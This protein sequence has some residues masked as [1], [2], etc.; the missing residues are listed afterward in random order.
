MSL[1]AVFM[2]LALAADDPPTKDAA[3]EQRLREINMA[4][5]HTWDIYLDAAHQVKAELIPRPVYLWT[6]P[7]KGSGQY[8]SVFVWVSQGRPAAIG[9]FFGHPI[10]QG[11][12]ERRRMVHEFHALAQTRLYPVCSDGDGQIWNPEA[13]IAL[14]PLPAAPPVEASPAK[15]LLTMR[16]IGREFGGNTVDWRKQRWELRLLPQPLYRYERPPG[17][18]VDGALLAFVTD[19]G[20]DPEVLLLL[21]ARQ[22]GGWHFAIMRFSDS[23]VYVQH[24]GKEVFKSVRG[25]DKERY[26]DE[27]TYQVLQKRYL[28]ELTEPK[29]SPP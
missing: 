25:V 6:N 5:A 18:I 12:S 8:G 15:R 19:A 22:E 14:Q 17:D 3:L 11:K 13:A 24:G 20:T 4:E 9:S 16:N 1:A 21:E 10:A 27:H 28:D 29:A 7:T 23:S 26:N 2:I